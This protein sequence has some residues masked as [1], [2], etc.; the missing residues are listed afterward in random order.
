M[1]PRLAASIILKQGAAPLVQALGG[2]TATTLR[3]T[4]ACNGAMHAAAFSSSTPAY[5]RYGGS[6]ISGGL[7]PVKAP[8]NLGITIVPERTAVVVER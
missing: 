1:L 7:V 8:R 3:H 5:S 4:Q 6:P 2:A